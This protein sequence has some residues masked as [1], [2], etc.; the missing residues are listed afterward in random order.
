MPEPIILRKYQ[1]DDLHKWA[2]ELGC[3][4][5]LYW[6]PG[7]GKTLV[8]IKL[9]ARMLEVGKTK[10]VLVIVPATL[11]LM[12]RDELEKDQLLDKTFIYKSKDKIRKKDLKAP[13]ERHQIHLISYHMFINT[14]KTPADFFKQGY[15]F[16]IL[17]ESHHIKSYKSKVF[18]FLDAVNK[19]ETKILLMTGTPYPQGRLDVYSQLT[20]IAP[21]VVGKNITAF[22]NKYCLLMNK[23]Y[24]KY[25]FN[26]KYDKEIDEILYKYCCFR[27][28]DKEVDIPPMTE[29]FVSYGLTEKQQEIYRMVKNYKVIQYNNEEGQAVD[30]PLAM[31]AVRM[32][33]CQQIASGI[34]HMVLK[35]PISPCK[36]TI[37]MQLDEDLNEKERLMVDLLESLPQ[38]KQALIWINYKKTGYHLLDILREKFPDNRIEI[39]NSDTSESKREEIL[40]SYEACKVRF[41]IAH[42]KTVGTGFNYFTKTQYHYWYECTTDYAVYE[43]AR[44]RLYR[45]GQND[46]TFEYF[47]IGDHTIDKFI[48]EAVQKKQDVLTYIFENYFKESLSTES[49]VQQVISADAGSGS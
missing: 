20:L 49:A 26:P 45:I 37:D 41:I 24:F 38:E 28:A 29:I 23:D 4:G 5:A 17:D 21:G 39:I 3:R 25:M 47:L 42:P 15:D 46:K 9:L 10:K 6:D 2:H 13:D 16:W 33:M 48:V 1:K 12:W 14:F 35:D 31:P 44:R 34:V 7:L 18:R 30:L 19:P 22:R 32:W 43:Q 11:I 8:S 36:H 27:Q 40:K